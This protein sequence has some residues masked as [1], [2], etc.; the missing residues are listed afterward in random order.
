MF[1]SRI[2][3]PFIRNYNTGTKILD[4]IGEQSDL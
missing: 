1:L 2:M 3:N 4:E